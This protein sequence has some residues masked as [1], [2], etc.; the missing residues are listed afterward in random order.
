MKNLLTKEEEISNEIVYRFDHGYHCYNKE[1]KFCRFCAKELVNVI[2]SVYFST[3]EKDK[4]VY[5]VSRKCP[6]YTGYWLS[7]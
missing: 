3:T 1:D 4:K 5:E 7:H 6:D 2:E